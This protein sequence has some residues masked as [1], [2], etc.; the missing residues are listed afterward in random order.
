MQVK[1]ISK[2]LELQYTYATSSIYIY[3]LFMHAHISDPSQNN[4]TTKVRQS[5]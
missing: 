5:H 2:S 3:V 1:S 4:A